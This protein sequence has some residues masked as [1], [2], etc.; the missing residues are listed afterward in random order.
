MFI[1]FHLC[2]KRNDLTNSG[3]DGNLLVLLHFYLPWYHRHSSQLF[4]LMWLFIHDSSSNIVFTWGFWGCSIRSR[5]VVITTDMFLTKL[6]NISLHMP[7]VFT[8]LVFS[9]ITIAAI[10]PNMKK[11]NLLR[12]WFGLIPPFW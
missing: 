5:A 10:Q 12:Y 3:S 2:L 4:N 8:D 9:P 7:E 11:L 6:S 1:S